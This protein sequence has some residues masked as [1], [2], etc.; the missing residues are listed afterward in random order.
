MI[1]LDTNVVSA[2]MLPQRSAEIRG[3]LDQ[4]PTATLWTTT[5]SVYE[6]LAGIDMLPEGRRRRALEEGFEASLGLFAG[7]ILAF[8]LDAAEHAALIL[9]RR[10]L[11][12]I[13]KETRDTQ[14]AGIAMSRKARLATRNIRDFQDL[15]LDLV[16]PWS[17]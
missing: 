14:I 3:W 10:L 7:R 15:D 13:N 2:L 11:S 9:S 1:V 17:A 5:V 16:D 4:Q 8:D 12:G 6:I